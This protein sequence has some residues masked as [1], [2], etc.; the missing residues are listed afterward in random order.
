VGNLQDWEN[1]GFGEQKKG[2]EYYTAKKKR[3]EDDNLVIGQKK[4]KGVSREKEKL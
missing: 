4:G 3:Q 1:R 2:L